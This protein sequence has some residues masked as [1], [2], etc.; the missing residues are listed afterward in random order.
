M[1][2]TA[3]SSNSKRIEIYLRCSIWLRMCIRPVNC[4]KFHNAGFSG[5]KFYIVKVRNLRHCSLTTYQH[6]CIYVSNMGNWAFGLKMSYVNSKI[7][8]VFIAN[9][10]LRR[11]GISFQN[12]EWVLKFWV[13]VWV[14]HH[15]FQWN[16]VTRAPL[17]YFIRSWVALSFKV[18]EWVSQLGICNIWPD[19]H[20]FQYLKA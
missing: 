11:G 12:R 10:T 1:G 13:S 5:Q 3:Q 2:K 14:K 19:L 6:K 15:G 17:L 4:P 8:T 18:C 7:L 16:C 20:F 9:I